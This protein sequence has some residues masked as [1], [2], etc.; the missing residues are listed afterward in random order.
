[1]P[2]FHAGRN[3]TPPWCEL[4][5]FEFLELQA[6]ECRTLRRQ[7]R[8]EEFIVCRGQ[9]TFAL[10]DAEFTLGEGGKLD[11]SGPG[12]K[13]L[14]LRA[15]GGTPLV[16]RMSGRW[17]AITSSGIFSAQTA[18]PPA[19]D[20]PYPYRK[21]TGFDNH[22]HD[23]DEYWILFE[24]AATAASEGSL[25]EVGPGDCIATGMGWHHDV[26]T[27]HDNQPLRAI[28]FEGTLEGRKRVGHLWEPKHGKAKP[29][30]AR[31]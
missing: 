5:R 12:V 20:T 31:V 10:G 11:L 4:E 2:V 18:T 30:R 7:G 16:C 1:M 14:K 15:A 28:W 3:Q 9:V 6:G 24:G 22:Y 19:F 26:V 21:T 27:V 13:S 23:C 17:Q 25:Y 8:K 29:V